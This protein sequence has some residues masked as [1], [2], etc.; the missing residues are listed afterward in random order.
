MPQM[1]K[2]QGGGHVYILLQGGASHFSGGG[3][4]GGGDQSLRGI[5]APRPLPEMKVSLLYVHRSVFCPY[6]HTGRRRLTPTSTLR[7]PTTTQLVQPWV[8]VYTCPVADRPRKH[9]VYLQQ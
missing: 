9:S 3:G 1:S 2:F 5:K 6:W 4:G 7:C 8:T